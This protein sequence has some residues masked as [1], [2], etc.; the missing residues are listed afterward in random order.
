MSL[1][2]VLFW[3]AYNHSYRIPKNISSFGTTIIRHVYVANKVGVNATWFKTGINATPFQSIVRGE[4]Y[5]E[6]M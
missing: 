4:D 3:R 1:E 5:A 6:R 2:F